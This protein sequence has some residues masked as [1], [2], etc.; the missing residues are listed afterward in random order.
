M[1]GKGEI[2]FSEAAF[3][4]KKL[5]QKEISTTNFV[6]ECRAK[7]ILAVILEPNSKTS[8]IYRLRLELKEG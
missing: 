2:T 5:D 7:K 3:R 4:D 1:Q 6:Y 8:N